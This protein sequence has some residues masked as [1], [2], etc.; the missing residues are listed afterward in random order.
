[1]KSPQ[2]AVF[3]E[4]NGGDNC[5]HHTTQKRKENTSAAKGNNK[6]IVEKV[7]KWK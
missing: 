6:E 7:R 4:R 2:P 3:N 5:R 1:M